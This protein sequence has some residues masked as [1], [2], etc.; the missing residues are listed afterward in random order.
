MKLAGN[1]H[2]LCD[3]AFGSL[4]SDR[5]I[6]VVQ[7]DGSVRALS[8]NIDG[9]LFESVANMADGEPVTLL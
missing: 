1:Q 2:W 9:Q 7:Y 5:I 8:M 6:D 4:H 3:R